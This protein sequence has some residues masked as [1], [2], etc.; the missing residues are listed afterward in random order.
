MPLDTK[1]SSRRNFLNYNYVF[2]RL[3]QKMGCTKFCMFFPLIRSKVK[4]RALDESGAA[5]T[6]S[7]TFFLAPWKRHAHE[8]EHARVVELRARG[9]VARGHLVDEPAELLL[10]LRAVEARAHR[11]GDRAARV[12]AREPLQRGERLDDEEAQQTT[13]S[14]GVRNSATSPSVMCKPWIPGGRNV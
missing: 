12:R 8:V 4:L 3:F 2:C 9:E 11:L 6:H 13:S 7:H 10:R 5:R 1:S 14:P